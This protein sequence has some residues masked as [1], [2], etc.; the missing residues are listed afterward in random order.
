[1]DIPAADDRIHRAI[2]GD[3]AWTELD[4]AEHAAANAYLDAAIVQDA[5]RASFAQDLLD[6]GHD[7][8]VLDAEG[9]VVAL[10]PD[11]TSTPV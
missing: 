6:A 4:P 7:A 10:H 3:L 5:E 9:T 8:I 11:G 2:N 1:M